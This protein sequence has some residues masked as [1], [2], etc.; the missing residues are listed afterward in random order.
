MAINKV[1]YGIHP[2]LGLEC[3]S[4][5][6]VHLP[7]SKNGRWKDRWVKGTINKSGYRVINYGGKVLYV[8]RIV[9]ETFLTGEGVVD[10]INRN[11]S[12]NCISNLR[13]VQISDNMRNTNSYDHVS[14]EGR[15]HWCDDKRQY[16]K[17]YAEM[18][19]DHIRE[20]QKQYYLLRKQGESNARS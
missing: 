4:D 13:L 6:Q 17:E 5:G 1:L 2:T 19:R 12:D 16:L 14:G 15:T 9:A 8:H 18:H 20:Y 10:H 11:K 3:S 7:K